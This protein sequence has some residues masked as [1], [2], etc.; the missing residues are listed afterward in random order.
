MPLSLNA[1]LIVWDDLSMFQ[2]NKCENKI[3]LFSTQPFWGH[4]KQIN[5]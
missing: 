4:L 5:K 2:D 1:C 3:W